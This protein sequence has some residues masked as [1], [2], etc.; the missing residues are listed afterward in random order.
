MILTVKS[1]AT[2]LKSIFTIYAPNS[3]RTLSRCYSWFRLP[4]RANLMQSYSLQKRLIVYVSIFS[5]MLG[6]VLV[7]A[8]YRIALEENQ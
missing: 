7:F 5:V 6:C 3:V 1:V 2:Q 8:A 4:F